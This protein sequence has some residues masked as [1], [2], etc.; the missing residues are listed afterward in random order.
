M[1][2]NKRMM[3]AMLVFEWDADRVVLSPRRAAR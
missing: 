2:T 1:A 3:V